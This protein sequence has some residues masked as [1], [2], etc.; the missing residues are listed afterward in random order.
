MLDAG[1]ID[2]SRCGAEAVAIEARRGLIEGLMV[3]RGSQ[4]AL[5][6]VAA[7]D[8]NRVDRSRRRHAHAAERS[9]ESAPG[10][11]RE[12]QIVDRG[13]EDV[14]YL[15]RDELFSRRHPDV[16]RL[17]ERTD[18]GARLL[19]E[20]RVRFVAENEVVHVGDRARRRGARTMRTSGS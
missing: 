11:V 10:S 5:L 19:P 13:R 2:D 1:G 7:D 16:Q 15:L 20:R 17:V 8:R 6:E 12:W 3:E 9:D 18:R 14:R 4:G